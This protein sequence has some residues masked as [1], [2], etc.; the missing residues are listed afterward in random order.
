MPTCLRTF[1][2]SCFMI[3]ISKTEQVSFDPNI[4]IGDDVDLQLRLIEDGILTCRFEHFSYMA[5]MTSRTAW[6][7]ADSLP[8]S[9]PNADLHSHLVVAPDKENMQVIDADA[10]LIMQ[11]YLRSSAELLFPLPVNNSNLH[12]LVMGCYVNLGPRISTCVINCRSCDE[13][14]VT[15]GSCAT[16]KTYAGLIVYDCAKKL[17]RDTLA[18]FQF[19]KDAQMVLIC[20]E[21][22]ELRSEVMRLDLEEY[23]RFR[24]R[25]E[26]QTATPSDENR[27][28]FYFLTGSYTKAS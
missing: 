20:R 23:W 25:D 4:Y 10:H 27:K 13:L 18:C 19:V 17:S 11:R 24:L 22:Y 26:Y 21:R 7:G 3:N 8:L 1:V 5:K 15:P 16:K 9:L 2:Q 6:R 12:V 28:A 14:V